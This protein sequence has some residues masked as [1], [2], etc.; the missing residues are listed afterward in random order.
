[1]SEAQTTEAAVTPA[2][3]RKKPAPPR[4]KP[5]QAKTEHP[6]AVIKT[7]VKE[8][9]PINDGDP[10]ERTRKELATEKKVT[11]V[12]NSTAED[13][14]DVF[15]ALNGFALTIQR[16]KEV[17][18]PFSVYQVLMD[19]KSNVYR[20]VKREDGEGMQMIETEI[21]RFSMSARF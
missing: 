14:D 11:V 12:I 20:Q 5:A 6:A 7:T 4:K 8:S 1:M 9:A 18:I 17:E 13:K 21:Q 3:P 15:V 10:T 2:P 16:D 19:A